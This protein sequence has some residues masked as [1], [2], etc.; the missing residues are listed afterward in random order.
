MKQRRLFALAI[1]VLAAAAFLGGCASY[2]NEQWKAISSNPT[3]ELDTL[4]QRRVDMD[5]AMT[6]MADENLRMFNQDMGR[7]FYT[8]RP[9]RLTP[10]PVPVP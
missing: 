1:P 3:P 6:V 4:Y 10:E 7:A 8:D 2:E 5:N 9:S